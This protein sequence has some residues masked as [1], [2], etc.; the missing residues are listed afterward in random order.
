M[1]AFADRLRLRLARGKPAAGALLAL[2]LLATT[3]VTA[4]GAQPLPLTFVSAPWAYSKQSPVEQQSPGYLQWQGTGDPSYYTPG[5]WVSNPTSC[6]WD[7]D[8]D[9]VRYA[10]G[11][12]LDPG[13]TAGDQICLNADM[14]GLNWSGHLAGIW[15]I[16]NSPNLVVTISFLPGSSFTVRPTWNSGSRAYDYKACSPTPAYAQGDPAL[17]PVANSNGGVAVAT[18]VKLTIKNIG[19]RRAKIDAQW[20]VGHYYTASSYC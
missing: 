6:V 7:V 15:L 5:S 18:Q 19:A 14:A 17:Q 13:A 4:V 12:T 20:K 2:S 10:S 1:F 9:Q 16:S 11:V 8:D 3:A